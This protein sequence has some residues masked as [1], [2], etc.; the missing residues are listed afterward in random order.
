MQGQRRVDPAWAARVRI[1]GLAGCGRV[2]MAAVVPE[3]GVFRR[4]LRRHRAAIG[5]HARN[6]QRLHREGKRDQQSEEDPDRTHEA[7]WSRRTGLVKRGHTP[8]SLSNYAT[9]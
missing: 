6:R 4:R 1:A 9:G 8:D 5:S 2:F 7:V 3:R